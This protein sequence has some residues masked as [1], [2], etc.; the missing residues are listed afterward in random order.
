M[1]SRLFNT[2]ISCGFI[3]ASA[4]VTAFT[5]WKNQQQLF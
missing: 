4:F 3:V 5:W 1:T 2:A